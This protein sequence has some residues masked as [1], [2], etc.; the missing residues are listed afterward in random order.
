MT[1]LSGSILAADGS[2]TPVTLRRSHKKAA[3]NQTSFLSMPKGASVIF[4]TQ[5]DFAENIYAFGTVSAPGDCN[6]DSNAT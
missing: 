6:E 4:T 5:S 1:Q 3:A 2:S